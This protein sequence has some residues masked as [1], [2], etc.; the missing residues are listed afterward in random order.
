MANLTVYQCF[1]LFSI[2]ICLSTQHG[3][4][5]DHK[6]LHSYMYPAVLFDVGRVIRHDCLGTCTVH[7]YIE[8]Q[9]EVEE[10]DELQL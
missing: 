9:I 1:H 2:Y 7:T 3:L 6:S 5:K 8:L 4:I 10:V